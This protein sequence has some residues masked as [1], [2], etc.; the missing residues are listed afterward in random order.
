LRFGG[1]LPKVTTVSATS[2]SGLPKSDFETPYPFTEDVEL[3][4]KETTAAIGD[5]EGLVASDVKAA[6]R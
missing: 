6:F 1:T 5:E 4:L 2:T 3:N